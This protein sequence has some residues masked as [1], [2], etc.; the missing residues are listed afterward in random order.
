MRHNQEAVNH[1]PWGHSSIAQATSTQSL[2]LLWA[3]EATGNL[4]IKIT[5]NQGQG[6]DTV[7][8]VPAAQA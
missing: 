7:C 5:Y 4:V 8:K 2:R 3:A 1:R 6:D